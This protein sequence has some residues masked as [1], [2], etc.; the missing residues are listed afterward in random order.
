[1]CTVPARDDAEKRKRGERVCCRLG[2]READSEIEV[3]VQEF[4][5]EPPWDQH[6]WKGGGVGTSPELHAG[7]RTVLVDPMGTLELERPIRVVP[8]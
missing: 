7:P 5:R 2:A 1:M 4:T 8:R 6:L 3:A